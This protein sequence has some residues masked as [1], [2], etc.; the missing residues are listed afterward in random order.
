MHG[1]QLIFSRD[2]TRSKLY[3]VSPLLFPQY[4]VL[5]HYFLPHMRELP[6]HGLSAQVLVFDFGFSDPTLT[7]A[8][9][10][11]QFFPLTLGSNFLALAITGVSDVPPSTGVVPAAGALS[12]VQ[13]SP[14][15]LVNMQQTHQGNTWQWMNKDVTNREAVGTA[16]NPLMLKSPPLIPA[17]DTLGCVVR[18]LGNASLRVQI[19]LIGG[20]F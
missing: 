12:G 9:M 20:S 19:T 16:E 7:V 13:V 2:G 15:Y 11:T 14:A 4:H 10:D 1:N 3:G 5:N 6:A 8:P 17:G 18:N